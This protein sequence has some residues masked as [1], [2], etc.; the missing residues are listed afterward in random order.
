ML[1][2]QMQSAKAQQAC[3]RP[4]LH[5]L[6]ADT[7]LEGAREEARKHEEERRKLLNS[8]LL[9]EQRKAIELDKL[10]VPEQGQEE[11]IK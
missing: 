3:R 9:A 6:V 7:H 1:E 4:E 2:R 5:C 11:Q 10:Q 8:R